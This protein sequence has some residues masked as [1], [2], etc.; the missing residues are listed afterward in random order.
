MEEN[1]W[2]SLEHKNVTSKITASWSRQVK[3]SRRVAF[4]GFIKSGNKRREITQCLRYNWFG[5]YSIRLISFQ[6]KIQFITL[7]N[8]TP[9]WSGTERAQHKNRSHNGSYAK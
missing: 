1:I 3:L 9:K 4:V 2:G 8:Q 7:L 5:G 6:L